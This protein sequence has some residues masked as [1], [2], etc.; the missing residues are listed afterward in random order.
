MADY[1]VLGESMNINV[2]SHIRA[3]TFELDNELMDAA[4]YAVSIDEYRLR[5]RESGM[6][7]SEVLELIGELTKLENTKI[8]GIEE[9]FDL[10]SSDK[11]WEK[12]G[13]EVKRF[14]LRISMAVFGGLT[15]I[16]PMLI[17]VLYPGLL[18]VLL[19][20]SIS[21]L[22]FGIVLAV[23]IKDAEPKDI[24]V[25]TAA[26]A[27]VLVVFVGTVGGS[28]SDGSGSQSSPG[29]QTSAGSRKSAG[30]PSFSN[31]KIGGIVAGSIIGT[32]ALLMVL[33]IVWIALA[34]KVP[35]IPY[36]FP[37]RIRT[38]RF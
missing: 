36:P 13:K 32:Y 16:I 15:L 24:V 30:S 25:T 11:S 17:M 4:A 20:T 26:Y 38:P 29:N 35:K 7:E 6:S 34:S 31:G 23:A 3:E 12:T 37:R 1:K 10:R 5:L 33:W 2:A 28:T 14:F 8:Q 27:A 19:T 21:V 18:T 22:V 9:V